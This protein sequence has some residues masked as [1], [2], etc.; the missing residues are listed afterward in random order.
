MSEISFKPIGIIHTPHVTQENMPIQSLSAT[1]VKATVELLPEYVDGLKDL[2]DFSHVILLFHF[3]RSEDFQLHVKP[4]MDTEIRGLFSTR[5]PKRPN[6]IGMS[7]VK[8]LG[9]EG[10]LLHVEDVDILD[11][12][13]LL[14][15]KPFFS[16]FDNRPDAKSGWLD[17]SW[18]ERKLKMKS[19]D[20]FK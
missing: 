12:T 8:L 15:I 19:D 10:N 4:F 13:P 9:I 20:R 11:G 1:G 5:A 7:T 3:H 2:E 18:E 6:G 16:K 17:R 14:D